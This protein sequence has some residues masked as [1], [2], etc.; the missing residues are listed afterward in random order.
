M[1]GFITLLRKELAAYF[2]SP[3]AYMVLLACSLVIGFSF[4]FWVNYF[5]TNNIKEVTVFYAMYNG[6]FFWFTLIIMCPI[7][8]MRIFSEE[9]KMG[10]IEMLM[11]APVKEWEVVLA[12]YF[13]TLLFFSIAWSPALLNTA[14]MHFASP[15]KIQISWGMILLPNLCLLLIGG[16]YLAIGIFTSVLTQNQI[17]S[18][19]L[20]FAMIFVL[21]CVGFLAN[22]KADQSTQDLIEYFS[23]MSQMDTYSKGILTTRPVVFYLS[24]IAFFLFL[25][26]RVLLMKRL[27]A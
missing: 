27:K 24:G 10:T 9:F 5:V 8:T 15:E 26:Q 6:F 14:W 19:I 7:L 13:A 21:F 22:G 18:A 25:T 3:V 1:R 11:T 16:F 12:K 20:S 2:V 4:W 17:V 23:V